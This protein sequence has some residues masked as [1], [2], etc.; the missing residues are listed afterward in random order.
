[1]E[2]RVGT[3]LI[4]PLNWLMKYLFVH[5]NFP[6]QFI[7]LA[8]ALV[9]QGHDV[10]AFVMRKGLSG[11]WQGVHLHEVK[12]IQG[13]TPGVHP[14]LIDFETKV[15]R[16]ESVYRAALALKQGG[17]EPDV[18]IA[19][20]GWGESL[21]LK[22]VWPDAKLAIYCEFNYAE[23]GLDVGFDP[24]FSVLDR[25]DACRLRLKNLNNVLHFDAANAAISPTA[26][27]AQTFPLPFRKNIQV[28]HDGI[29]TQTIQ[30]R[31]DVEFELPDG[32]ILTRQDEVITFANRNLEPYRGYHVFMRALPQLLR[33]RPQARVL[34]VG[35]DR[36]SYGQAPKG[37]TT[38]KQTFIDEVRPQITDADWQRVV[39]LPQLPRETFLKFLQVSRVH[40]YFTYPFVAGW[41]LLEAMS[42]GCAVVGSDTE[43]VRE[44][45]RHRETGVLTP[46]FDVPQLVKNIGVMLDN[47]KLRTQCA[48]EAR[49]FV[50]TQYDL[51]SVCLPQL[52]QW[53]EG[54]VKAPKKAAKRKAV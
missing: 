50:Q 37:K 51:Q 10:H 38:W 18:I 3:R 42:A 41:S 53:A 7:H 9:K 34:I 54:L 8:P 39:F 35:G 49:R 27:Q 12:P 6:G 52:I 1:M 46:F 48:A 15:I 13:S 20:P 2:N 26:F 45:I 44:F 31:P 19:H 11:Q 29:D 5:Q 23:S 32:T 33:E 40:V 36:T 17:Y 14:W 47:Q 4:Q 16:G 28:L 30:P 21:F 22:D 25:G 24:E 43:P